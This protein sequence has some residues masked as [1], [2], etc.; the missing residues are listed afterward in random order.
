MPAKSSPQRQFDT[1]LLSLLACPACGGELRLDDF[2][3]VCAGC[4]RGYPIVEGIPVLIAE[5]AAP[6]DFGG[7]GIPP[8]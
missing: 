8:A 7:S 5:R 2:R 6:M 1:A 4:G 3:L